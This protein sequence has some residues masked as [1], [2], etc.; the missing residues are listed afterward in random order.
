MADGRTIEI[1][2]G[3][4]SR[5]AYY[6]FTR[7]L[8][9]QIAARPSEVYQDTTFGNPGGAVLS[10]SKPETEA[11]KTAGETGQKIA[12]Q[13]MGRSFEF[14]SRMPSSV[15]RCQRSLFHPSIVIRLPLSYV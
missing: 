1:C 3:K 12:G 15:S 10:T 7:K 13:S 2:Q 8:S 14:F 6:S 5:R 9:G 4:T 11:E